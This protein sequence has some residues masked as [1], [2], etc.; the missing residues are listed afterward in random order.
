[1]APDI[2]VLDEPTIGLDPWSRQQFIDIIKEIGKRSTLILVTH[3]FDLLKIVDE[4]HFLWE[5]KIKNV[6]NSFE[7]FHEHMFDVNPNH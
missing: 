4:I 1:M 3:D 5:G 6:Y 7:S 2:M